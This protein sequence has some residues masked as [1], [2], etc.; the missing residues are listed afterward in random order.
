VLLMSR[1][2]KA[3]AVCCMLK[4]LVAAATIRGTWSTVRSVGGLR[5]SGDGHVRPVAGILGELGKLMEGAFRLIWARTR[6]LG[7]WMPEVAS[8][9]CSFSFRNARGAH[10]SAGAVAAIFLLGVRVVPD[11]PSAPC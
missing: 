3:M 5:E 6:A 7:I 2:C 8:V 1:S 11:V 9:S 10:F 4:T